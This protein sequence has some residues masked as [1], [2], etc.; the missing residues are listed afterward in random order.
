MTLYL[1]RLMAGQKALTT[2]QVHK[3]TFE[4]VR[5][6]AFHGF[7]VQKY[8]NGLARE[9]LKVDILHKPDPLVEQWAPIARG[10]FMAGGFIW[11]Y[12]PT[13]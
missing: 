6:Y 2:E 3:D 8:P 7:L 11:S 13:D 4:G 10:Q 5:L 12:P 9:M 1:L